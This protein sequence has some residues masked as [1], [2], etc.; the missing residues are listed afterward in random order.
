MRNPNE[1]LSNMYLGRHINTKHPHHSQ[2]GFGGK[3]SSSRVKKCFGGRNVV[4]RCTC[5][6]PGASCNTQPAIMPLVVR[7]C[8]TKAE[9]RAMF[10]CG[11]SSRGKA[12]VPCE[13]RIGSM[14]E[15]LEPVP[16]GLRDLCHRD[17][18]AAI[19]FSHCGA[20]PGVAK[21]SCKRS[22]RM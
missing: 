11:E 14:F 12:N 15:H 19:S 20:L 8:S 2:R 5:G 18:S 4:I 17:R 3:P 10:C 16:E 6:L 13:L 1:L 22:C 7:C 9:T 21:A